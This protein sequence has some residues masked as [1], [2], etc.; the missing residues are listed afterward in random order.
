MGYLRVQSGTVRYDLEQH[1]LKE[2]REK[3]EAVYGYPFTYLD[4]N[5]EKASLRTGFKK[6]KTPPRSRSLFSSLCSRAPKRAC[7]LCPGAR[8][9]KSAPRPRTAALAVRGG[10]A[11]GPITPTA[12]AGISL[13]ANLG[14][15]AE[16]MLT[17]SAAVQK[18]KS[19]A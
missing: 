3:Y 14:Y 7:R 13:V 16:L 12:A 18:Q 10:A 5:R 15:I 1:E 2:V 9:P 11:I 8:R 4:P 17:P 6:K 19:Y